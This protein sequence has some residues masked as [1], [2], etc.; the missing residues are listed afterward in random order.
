MLKWFAG[1]HSLNNLWSGLFI[2]TFHRNFSAL[3]ILLSL[4]FK[5]ELRLSD[6]SRLEET[7]EAFFDRIRDLLVCWLRCE[8]SLGTGSLFQILAGSFVYT[9]MVTERP[10]LL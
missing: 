6:G 10:K 4:V 1:L 7:R 9:M 5:A 2:K 8:L 3:E